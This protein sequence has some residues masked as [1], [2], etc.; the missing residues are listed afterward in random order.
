MIKKVLSTIIVLWVCITIYA[1][2]FNRHDYYF[3]DST[4]TLNTI[5]NAIRVD[6]IFYLA[7]GIVDSLHD[8]RL[9]L[10]KTDLTGNVID[11]RIVGEP[12]FTLG[13]YYGE[14]MIIDRDSFFLICC[15]LQDDSTGFSDGYIVKFDRNLDTLWTRVYDIPPLL[16][17]C[18]AFTNPMN[19]FSVIR[20]CPDGNY[21]LGCNYDK[22][23]IYA[24]RRSAL[25][26][27]DTAGNVLWWKA[28]P[29]YNEI[30]DIELALD[31]GFY[32]PENFSNQLHV[33][34]TDSLG[35][36]QWS[37][38]V[39]HQILPHLIPRI[40]LFGN[41]YYY[42]ASWHWRDNTLK[43]SS[44]V[45]SKVNTI[46]KQ[47]VWEKVF[48]IH[49][50]F[51]SS[52]VYGHILMELDSQSNVIIAGTSR[53]D[54][55]WGWGYFK[56][57]L[58]KLNSQGD[59]LWSRYYE[60][61]GHYDMY[62]FNDLVLMPD[63][64]Y[65][66]FG[67]CFPVDLTYNWAAWIVRTDSMGW[68]PGSQ[69]VGVEEINIGPP[70]SSFYLFPNP[71]DYYVDIRFEQPSTGKL[72]ITDMLGREVYSALVLQQEQIRVP[73]TGLPAGNYIVKFRGED[74][75]NSQGR[76]LVVGGR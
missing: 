72:H 10:V 8:Q 1:Q 47:L 55:A 68:A 7:V 13:P 38:Q 62:K 42:A 18:P 41:E 40:E 63:G 14:S 75:V 48:M 71:A 65:A 64:G 16:A 26:K 76:V 46:T 15:W 34:K 20:Q 11:K 30:F 44:L 43:T 6:S 50:A 52:E 4:N 53:L 58:L 29:T 66:M 74:G 69:S 3:G 59:S 36:V 22:D 27:I 31:S 35:N 23:C 32:I 28:Y 25:C 12:H 51:T 60:I 37:V 56:G 49:D 73:T 17:G 54:S 21:I 9:T 45:I 24:N 57:V 19:Y 70:L 33:V 5:C 39:N 2:P 67:M 61:P